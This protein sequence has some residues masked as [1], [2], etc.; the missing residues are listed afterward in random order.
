MK[1]FPVSQEAAHTLEAVIPGDT[2]CRLFSGVGLLY[3]KDG[4]IANL[5]THRH[6]LHACTHTLSQC[7][8]ALRTPLHMCVFMHTPPHTRLAAQH[9]LGLVEELPPLLA[10]AGAELHSQGFLETCI[11][12]SLPF[13]EP[14]RGFL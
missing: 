10:A 9:L 5:C 6:T 7:L 1:E 2:G 11:S 8:H 3:Q 4:A 13:P 14:A 12:A